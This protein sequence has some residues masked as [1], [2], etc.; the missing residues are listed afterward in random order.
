[1]YV[2][3]HVC[4]RVRACVCVCAVHGYVR[5]C[6]FTDWSVHMRVKFTSRALWAA[7]SGARLVAGP[8]A[9]L[10]AQHLKIM[11]LDSTEP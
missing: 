11:R 10:F 7:L 1:M 9:L 2:R 3:M 6:V 8:A 4:T 5:V